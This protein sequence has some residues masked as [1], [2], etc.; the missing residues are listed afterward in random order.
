METIHVALGFDNNYAQHAAVTICS[1]L[2]NNISD[3]N[4]HFYLFSP[5]LAQEH[6]EKISNMISSYNQHFDEIA[7]GNFDYIAFNEKVMQKYPNITFNASASFLKIIVEDYLPH[8]VKKV[9]S[10]DS[11]IIVL[12][13]LAELYDIE[14]DKYMIG[15]V[16]EEISKNHLKEIG[17]DPKD[18]YF[19]A[20]ILLIDMEKWREERT[21]DTLMDIAL[22]DKH[23]FTLYDQDVLN[24]HFKDNFYH[25]PSKFNQMVYMFNSPAL[26]SKI[27]YKY[28][29]TP[30]ISREGIIHYTGIKPWKYECLHPYKD[31]Y[32][33]F[34]E[35]TAYNDYFVEENKIAK[36]LAIIN[37]YY[38][39]RKIYKIVKKISNQSVS[40]GLNNT[41][42]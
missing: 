9:I 5:D 4:Y 3:R 27:N 12:S 40:K 24:T 11:D 39:T 22:S 21:G 14:L 17:F 10:L 37:A 31:L 41:F 23:K 33:K 2:E 38:L 42:L 34:L 26:L 13:D 15:G 32:F 8:D 36:R 30:G 19:N 35:K 7:T 20:G 18:S 1:I 25:L 29:N 16:C 28:K 6:M